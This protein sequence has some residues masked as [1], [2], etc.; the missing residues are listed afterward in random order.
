MSL[1]WTHNREE[2]DPLVGLGFVVG[3]AYVAAIVLLVAGI[4]WMVR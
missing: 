2:R 1:Y 3:L 4:A